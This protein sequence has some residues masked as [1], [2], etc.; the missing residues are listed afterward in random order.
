MRRGFLAVFTLIGAAVVLSAQQPPQS[1]PAQPP[2]GQQPPAQQ[3]PA[4]QPPQQQPPVFKTGT[5]QVRVDVTV[6]D[7]KGEPVRDLTKDD[8]DVR[9]DGIPQAIDTIKLIEATGAAPDDDMSLPIRSA[10]HAYAEAARDDIRVFVIF[11][12]EYHIGEMAPAIRARAALTDFVQSA[13]GPTDLVALMDQLTP[14]DTIEFTRDRRALAEKVHKLK[15]RQGV[16]IPP[17]SPV[18]EAQMY[19]SRDIEML[20]AQ[21]TASA[22]DATIGFLGSIKEGR[23]AILLVSQTIGRLGTSPMDT[24]SWLE[25]TIRTANANNTT[26]YTFDP[27]GLDVNIRPS[28]FLH[29]LATETGGRQFSNNYPAASLREVVKNASAFYLLGYA[30]AKNPADGKFHKIAVHVK[31]PNVDVK[32]RTGYF[33]P[34]TTEMEAAKKKAAENTAPPEISNA[35]SKLVDAPH[36]PV[37]G[38]LWAGAAPGPDGKP[39]VTVVWTPRDATSEEGISI[40][41]SG[42]G[43][44][45]FFDGPLRGGRMT[46]DAAPGTLHLRRHLVDTDGALTDR[47]EST[48]D[49]PDFAGSPLTISSPVVF[50]AST[51]LELRAIQ[52]EP[53]PAPFAGR[54]FE[55]GDR[56]IV[57]FGVVGPAAADATVTA[58]LLSRKGTALATL[59]LKT[60]A[61]RGYE[62]DLPM[63]SVARGE[64]VISIAASHGA[65][66]AKTLLS[67]RV[68]SPQQ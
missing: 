45:V 21:V 31:R 23:K 19:R 46:F 40:R 10:Q 32:S 58:T 41:A 26:I 5:N 50:R 36:I 34:S 20:R 24:T 38:D 9:E 64:Y 52:A 4:Q 13:F 39:R 66:Q 63:G 25:S 30:S 55:R 43:G 47:Q 11:W 49:V 62:I 53:D 18:E 2:A 54:Q 68:G 14:S 12:D 35:L 59:P 8:F 42:D 60:T 17:R 1:P 48:L 16:Y 65:D 15:G 57:R 6:T 67:F 37:A 33:A 29:A 61:S 56:V 3:P 28:D 7:R 27:R 51:P 44:R 22:L